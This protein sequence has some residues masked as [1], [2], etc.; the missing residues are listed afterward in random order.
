MRTGKKLVCARVITLKGSKYSLCAL[1]LG[2]QK[3]SN[4]IKIDVEPT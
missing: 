1:A 3:K 2:V 4:E